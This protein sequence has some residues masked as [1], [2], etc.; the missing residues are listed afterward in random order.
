MFLNLLNYILTCSF[1]I[2]TM[3]GQVL[4]VFCFPFSLNAVG[5]LKGLGGKNLS[6]AALLTARV[7]T[8]VR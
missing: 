5:A 2:W 3:I 1:S 6:Q 8:P 7:P 4:G